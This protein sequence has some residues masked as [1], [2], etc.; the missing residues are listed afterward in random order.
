MFYP[1]LD[2]QDTGTVT[3]VKW[4]SV[5]QTICK[6]CNGNPQQLIR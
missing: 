5:N 3:G 4:I 2:T 1:Y 6:E